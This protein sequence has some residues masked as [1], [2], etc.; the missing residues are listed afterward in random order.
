M[1][2]NSPFLVVLQPKLLQPGEGFAFTAGGVIAQLQTV[3]ISVGIKCGKLLGEQ[4]RVLSRAVQTLG[5]LEH[6]FP[7]WK[8]FTGSPCETV[9]TAQ[10]HPPLT[11]S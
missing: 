8:D 6:Q 9:N 1:Y 11:A 3:V 10:C 2:L 5:N 4:D 7:N